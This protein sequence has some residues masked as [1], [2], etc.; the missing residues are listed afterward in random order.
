MWQ[1][2]LSI[3]VILGS[4]TACLILSLRAFTRLTAQAVERQAQILSILLRPILSPAPMPVV[5]QEQAEPSL[6]TWLEGVDSLDLME[7]RVLDWEMPE[8]SDEDSISP[9]M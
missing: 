9:E 5:E 2:V 6:P 1:L 4:L 3:V 7:G 8:I